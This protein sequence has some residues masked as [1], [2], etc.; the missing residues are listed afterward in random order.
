MGT[1]RK[2]V[3]SM[4]D[5]RDKGTGGQGGDLRLPV[6][7][8]PRHRVTASPR[9]LLF[10]PLCLCIPL[11]IGCG[12][13]ESGG[14]SG[15]TGPV[16]P[17]TSGGKVYV[18]NSWPF[19]SLGE[20]TGGNLSVIDIETNQVVG[21]I[22]V[23]EVPFDLVPSKDGRLLYVVNRG[24]ENH[25][26]IHPAA[27]KLWVM[28]RETG[29]RIAEIAL[30][31][32]PG[33]IR[34]SPEEDRAY[35]IVTRKIGRDVPRGITVIDLTS[36]QVIDTVSLEGFP[37]GLAISSDGALLC[38]TNLAFVSPMG[39]VALFATLGVVDVET[40]ALREIEVDW[41]A[42]GVCLSSDD[43]LAY[44]TKPYDDVVDVIDLASGETVRKIP[45]GNGPQRIAR[46]PDG[47]RLYVPN[48]LSED[49]SVID[50]GT[51]E[52]IGTVAVGPF[53][54]GVLVTPDGRYVYV[55]NR[56]PGDLWQGVESPEGSVTVID[57]AD[58][59]VIAT[60]PVEEEPIGMC[61]VLE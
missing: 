60:I 23:G 58:L 10:L 3:L 34:L 43:R 54:E 35:V 47:T 19:R 48:G 32:N 39:D 17:E 40:L 18:A 61:A 52:V 46:S 2:D 11:L 14:P 33:Q 15:P 25:P 37:Y 51:N 22:P 55:A 8:S 44:V 38:A 26:D 12:G 16:L 42:Y 27:S 9:L 13:D 59:S 1:V 41:P 56:N 6:S 57:A 24:L 28:E 29:E 21:S 30:P 31:K 49:V 45:V 20:Q 7:M 53:P 36:Y 50:T 4:D 5:G